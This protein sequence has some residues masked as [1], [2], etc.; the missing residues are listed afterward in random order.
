[1]LKAVD[2][3]VTRIKVETTVLVDK[4]LLDPLA[5]VALE[6]HHLAQLRVWDNGAIAGCEV[7]AGGLTAS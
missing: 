3:N 1:M 7:L 5:L 4:E 6:L 2:L